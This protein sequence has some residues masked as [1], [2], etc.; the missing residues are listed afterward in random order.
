[1]H[2]TQQLLEE[3]FIFASLWGHNKKSLNYF[4]QDTAM[5]DANIQPYSLKYRY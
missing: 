5:L 1:M 3:K 4:T 2:P